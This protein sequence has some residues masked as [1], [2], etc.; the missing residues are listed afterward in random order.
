MR[1]LPFPFVLLLTLVLPGCEAI[2]SI[3]QAGMWVG[4]LGALLL[5]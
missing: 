4:L 1:T 3:F 5:G 2:A